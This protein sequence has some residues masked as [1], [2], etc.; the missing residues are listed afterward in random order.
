MRTERYP[1]N[2]AIS[3]DFLERLEEEYFNSYVGGNR[4]FHSNFLKA[5]SFELD[6]FKDNSELLAKYAEP[7]I[8]ADVEVFDLEE[9]VIDL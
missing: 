4:N 8:E 7:E 6:K 9:P 2:I 5:I 3:R 1:K